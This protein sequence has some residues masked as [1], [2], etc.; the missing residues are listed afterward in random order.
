MNQRQCTLSI[1][2]GFCMITTDALAI[3]PTGLMEEVPQ[4]GI[5]SDRISSEPVSSTRMEFLDAVRAED[6]MTIS[7]LMPRASD[8]LVEDALHL[9]VMLKKPTIANILLAR[10][11]D[12]NQKLH[13]NYLLDTAVQNNDV[14]MVRLLVAHGADVDSPGRQGTPIE[15]ARRNG[16]K[17]IEKILKPTG[18]SKQTMPN[19]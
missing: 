8:R 6:G 14:D 13:G 16:Q 5:A 4:S 19:E 10:E 9:S 7:A 3:P 11:I 15:A 2:M 12:V 18:G 1:I 17:E